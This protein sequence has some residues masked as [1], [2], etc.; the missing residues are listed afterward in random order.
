M[1]RQ[2]CG[3]VPLD[4]LRDRSRFETIIRTVAAVAL[5]VDVA[6]ATFGST[7]RWSIDMRRKEY[8]VLK[9]R[10]QRDNEEQ[11]GGIREEGL[12]N[13]EKGLRNRYVKESKNGWPKSN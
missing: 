12:R 7:R 8:R 2:S 10:C 3:I 4:P 9:S 13:R 5:Q 1:S 6:V 11:K